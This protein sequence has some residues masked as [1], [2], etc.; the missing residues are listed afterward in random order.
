MT[1]SFPRSLNFGLV[2]FAAFSVALTASAQSQSYAGPEPVP[3]PPPIV[4]PAET[5]YPGTIQL[6]V[7]LTDNARRIASVHETVPVARGELTLLYPQWI[8]GNHSPTGP[9]SKIGGLTVTAAGKRIQWVR[10]PVN[11]YAFHIPVPAGVNQVDVDFQFLSPLRAREGRISISD[12]IADLA[13]NTVV[14]YP[15]G[16]FSRDIHFA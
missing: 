16:H 1:L 8:P 4:A 3:Y 7:D 13:W 15:A 10:D 2:L 5:P 12:E 11:V 6:L 9:I 14:L